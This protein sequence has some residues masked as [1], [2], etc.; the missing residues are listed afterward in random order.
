MKNSGTITY[1][2]PYVLKRNSNKNKKNTVIISINRARERH[3]KLNLI[4][5]G[6]WVVYAETVTYGK[7]RVKLPFYNVVRNAKC[8]SI[9]EER[10]K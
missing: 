8:L 9:S 7:M 3:K 5:C 1:G 4:K 2:R 6:E 10:V